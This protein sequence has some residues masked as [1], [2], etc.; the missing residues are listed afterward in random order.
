MRPPPKT[1]SVDEFLQIFS[2]SALNAQQRSSWMT[3]VSGR[4]IDTPRAGACALQAVRPAARF[5]LR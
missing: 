3:T 2:K 5:I 1:N 4:W